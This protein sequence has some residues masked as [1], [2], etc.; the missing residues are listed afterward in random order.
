MNIHIT[1]R[2]GVAALVLLVNEGCSEPSRDAPS[3]VPSAAAK[4]DAP[5]ESAESSEVNP[6]LL[7]RFQAISAPGAAE[8]PALVALGKRLFYEP[9]LSRGGDVSCN[10]CHDLTA[11]GVDHRA[12]S[13]GVDGHRGDRNAPTVYNAAGFFVQFWDGRAASLEEQAKGPILNPSEMGMTSPDHVV[14]RLRGVA[15][16]KA[17]FRD[18]FPDQADAVTYDNVGRAI[19]AFERGLVTPG[20]WDKYLLGDKNALSAAEKTGL[21]TFLNSGCMVCHTGAYLGGSMFERVGAVEPWPNQT[22]TGRMKVTHAE[23]DRMMFKVPTLRN[24]ARTSPYFHDGSAQTLTDAV[25][26]MGKHQLGLDLSPEENQAIV[27]WLGVLT[28]DMPSEYARRP[29]P[30]QPVA[31]K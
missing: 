30:F 9:R 3:P 10:S 11:Y 23:G 21:K 25:Q 24:V 15:G 13:T 26:Q 8:N 20:R 12:T 18:A 19:A 29:E 1:H 28:G 2:I 14:E 5:S 16:Y 7:R 31:F 4:A 27:T 17:A 6:R 22:D